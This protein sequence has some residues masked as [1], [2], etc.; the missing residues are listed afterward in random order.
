MSLPD[1][2]FESGEIDFVQRAI[3]YHWNVVDTGFLSFI[4]E[5]VFNACGDS[6]ALNVFD[7][8]SGNAIT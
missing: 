3:V 8:R 6:F 4:A 1:H 5:V 2:R 7:K